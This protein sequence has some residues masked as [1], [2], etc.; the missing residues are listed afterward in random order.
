MSDLAHQSLRTMIWYPGEWKNC[1][2]TE[3]SDQ[4]ASSTYCYKWWQAFPTDVIG[5]FCEAYVILGQ[6][7]DCFPG[8]IWRLR[9]S[10]NDWVRTSFCHKEKKNSLYSS[11][12]NDV[13]LAWRLWQNLTTVSA[14]WHQNLN[15]KF[16]QNAVKYGYHKGS[17]VYD[18]DGRID[19]KGNIDCSG[20]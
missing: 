12:T 6:S 16:D 2:P 3:L 13:R 10:G 15:W 17:I 9:T 19:T 11:A 1:K 7:T 4:T 14:C 5:V 8:S 20:T 18:E